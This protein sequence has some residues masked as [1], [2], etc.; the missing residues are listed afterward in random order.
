MFDSVRELESYSL[1][2]YSNFSRSTSKSRYFYCNHQFTDNVDQISFL[3]RGVSKI[4]EKHTTGDMLQ[5]IRKVRTR[6]SSAGISLILLQRADI[7]IDVQL[8][9]ICETI[10]HN[11]WISSPPISKLANC[12]MGEHSTELGMD[13]H[14]SHMKTSCVLPLRFRTTNSSTKVNAVDGG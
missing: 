14:R 11:I 12:L 7:S 4:L 1:R 6:E 5:C 3:F 13:G 9:A 2:V 10:L 8:K